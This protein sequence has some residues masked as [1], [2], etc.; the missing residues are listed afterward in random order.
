MKVRREFEI[1]GE[2]GARRFAVGD[3]VPPEMVEAFGLARKGLVEAGAVK[4]P[5][6]DRAA[7]AAK[8]KRKKV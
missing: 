5:P 3:D 4:S 1:H 2:G 7:P 8:R 6:S